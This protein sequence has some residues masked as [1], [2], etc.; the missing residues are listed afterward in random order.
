MMQDTIDY[1]KAHPTELVKD[2]ANYFTQNELDGALFDADS[3]CRNLVQTQHAGYS[4]ELELILKELMGSMSEDSFTAFLANE[5]P[6]IA[7]KVLPL[8]LDEEDIP[9]NYSCASS[10]TIARSGAANGDYDR[11]ALAAMEAAETMSCDYHLDD[12]AFS[13]WASRVV[14][15]AVGHAIQHPTFKTLV[16][17][18]VES[19]ITT[20][21]KK[22]LE[23]D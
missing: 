23:D 6:F 4:I 1:L 21:D 19:A 12:D 5:F 17:A 9:E 13:D 14:S 18:Y 7:D 10:R 22:D 15:I 20:F 11:V 3:Y 16:K 8:Q 2:V